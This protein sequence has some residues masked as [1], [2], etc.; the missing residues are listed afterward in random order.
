[1]REVEVLYPWTAEKAASDRKEAE[2]AGLYFTVDKGT[3][4]RYRWISEGAEVCADGYTTKT[5]LLDGAGVTLY[6][7][8]EAVAISRSIGTRSGMRYLGKD[9][10]GSVRSVTIE[11]GTLED[12]YEYD[13]FGT[14]Y[15]GDLANGMNL[16]YTGKPY[17]SATGLYNYGYRDYRPE[18][19]R[20]TT[21]DPIRDG[22][23]WFA[24]VNNDP[25]NYVDLWGLDT[26][27]Y[28]EEN[29]TLYDSRTGIDIDRTTTYY[30]R[31]EETI[32]QY[33][34]RAIDAFKREVG[35]SY[36]P[37]KDDPENLFERNEWGVEG[38]TFFSSVNSAELPPGIP[39]P[40]EGSV[41]SRNGTAAEN[42]FK[43]SCNN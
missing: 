29:N 32:T 40:P 41:A 7:K 16:G 15:Q 19:A 9:L 34:E 37:S 12:R 3:G 24:Y 8:G 13:A 23:N 42:G 20:F 22:N 35:Q 4:E 14:P 39:N 1:M 43:T 6:G 10:L 30:A 11:T 28:Y 26:T 31:S 2:E 5:S 17:D 36:R 27:Y 38:R 25:V 18:T 21:I 33:R